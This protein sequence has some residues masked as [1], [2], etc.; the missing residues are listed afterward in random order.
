MA[1]LRNVEEDEAGRLRAFRLRFGRGWDAESKDEEG[2]GET[3][4]QEESLM[5]LISGAGG[6]QDLRSTDEGIKAGSGTG[7][8]VEMVTVR[9]DG[10]LVKVPALSRGE[11]KGKS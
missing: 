8:E 2:E 1:S 7:V 10:V 5:D 3:K 6:G 11:R 9:K 4:E